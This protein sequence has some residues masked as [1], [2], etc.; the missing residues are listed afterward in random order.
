MYNIPLV[1]LETVKTLKKAGFE[2]FLVGG[3]V[4]DLMLHM[5]PKDWD[6]TTNAKPEEI[7]KLFPKTVYENKFGTVA[8]I[9]ETDDLTLKIIEITPYRLE[10]KYSDKRHPDEVRFTRNLEDDLKRRDFTI[11][12]MAMDINNVSRETIIDHFNGSADLK[13]RI[14]RAVGDPN[15]RF[16]EDALRMLRAIRL[17]TELGFK[18]SGETQKAIKLHAKL[19][20]KISQER[21]RD[22]FVKII[23]TDKPSKGIEMMHELGALKYVLPELEEGIDIDQNKAHKFTVWEHNLR[24]LDH[25]A[26]KGFPLEIRLSSLLHDI[27]KPASRMWSKEKK[28][29]T[30]YGHEIIGARMSVKI[31]SRLK[32]SKRTIDLITKFVRYHLFFSDTEIITLSAVRRTVR[33]IGPENVWDL[34]KVRFCDRVG[35]GRPKETPYRLRKYESMIEEAMR[36]PLSVG[37]LKMDGKNIMELLKIEPG[38][39]IGFILHALLEEVL[40][41]PKKNTVQ[42]LE[43]RVKELGKLSEKELEKIGKKAKETKEEVEKKEIE[44]IRKKW[45]V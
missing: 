45:W 35:M 33:N 6:I 34:M 27:G 37:M 1:V 28:D 12:A 43:K 44:E 40:D 14:I 10:S 8:V 25:A 11:N 20:L 36:A 42:Y 13:S 41:E 3:C 38:P 18:V 4:R 30:F 29:W 23:M 26:F 5:K 39:K 31:L 22:E 32:F 16:N 17:A 2:A 19:L 9:H 7:I 24:S 15:D 21:I